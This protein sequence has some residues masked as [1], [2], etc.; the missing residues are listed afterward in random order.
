AHEW[1]HYN[2]SGTGIR[3]LLD[4][5]IYCK[6]KGDNLNRN[7]ITEQCRQLEIT[8]FEK[9]RRLLAVKIFS[10]DTLPDLTE[11]E[12]EMLMFYLTAGTYGT[13]DNAI[14]KKLKDQSKLSFWVHSIFIP[15]KQMAASVPF[16]AKSPLLYPVGIFWRTFRVMLFKQDKIKQT[17]KA[18]NKYGK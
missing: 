10:S 9:E 7:Y 8:D 17:I 11:S 13:F 16:T 14:K 6:V 15:R 4:C 3:S 18:V 2:G 12:Q 5:Y 1:K